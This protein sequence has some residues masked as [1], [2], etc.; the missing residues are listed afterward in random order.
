M[1]MPET[2]T[3]VYQPPAITLDLAIVTRAGSPVSQNSGPGAPSVDFSG[4]TK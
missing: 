2:T 3:K 4:P 1:N